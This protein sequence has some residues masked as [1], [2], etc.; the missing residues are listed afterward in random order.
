MWNQFLFSLFYRQASS[1]V[2]K[3]SHLPKVGP[4]GADSDPG[5]SDT[6]MAL[7]LVPGDHEAH[8]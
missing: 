3:F 6:P 7:A 5:T 2:E 4:G 8:T 1:G